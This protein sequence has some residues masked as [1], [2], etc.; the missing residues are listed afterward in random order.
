MGVLLLIDWAISIYTSAQ[1]GVVVFS[2]E[3]RVIQSFL[4]DKYAQIHDMKI[5]EED[6]KEY[7]YGARNNNAEGIKFHAQTGEIVLKLEY[8]AES[9]LELKAFNPTATSF[10][11]MATRATTSSSSTRQ[12]SISSTLDRKGTS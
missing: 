11:R 2:P 12:E 6:G 8:P 4:G 3:G 1:K 7:I 10:S 5:R 9:G